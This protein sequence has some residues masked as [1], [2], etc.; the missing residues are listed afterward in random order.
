MAKNTYKE[1]IEPSLI[2][3]GI[4]GGVIL[5]H[6]VVLHIMNAT[7]STYSIVMGYILPIGLYTYALYTYRKEYLG[8]VMTYSK[9]LGMGV[10][11]SVVYAMI[12]TGY[13]IVLVKLIDPNYLELVKQMAE[14]K[15]LKKGLNEEAIEQTMEMSE[16]FRSLGFMTIAGFLGITLMGTIYSLIIMIFLKKEPKD[17]FANVEAQ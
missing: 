2:Y 12:S 17:P 4:I 7:F 6:T 14:E 1:V 10:M 5:L 9:G 15:M 3:G 13:L 8:D 11:F 16:R